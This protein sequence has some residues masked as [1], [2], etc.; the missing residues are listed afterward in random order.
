VQSHQAPAKEIIRS[1]RLTL[2]L[3]I[4]QDLCVRVCVGVCVCVFVEF[5]VATH[6]SDDERLSVGVGL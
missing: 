2:Y 4:L 6:V 5:Y 1:R 3:V